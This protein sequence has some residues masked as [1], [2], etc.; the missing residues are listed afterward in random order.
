MSSYSETV[1][2]NRF[3]E[4]TVEKNQADLR[5]LDSFGTESNYKSVETS[6]KMTRFS[7]HTVESFSPL[8]CKYFIMNCSAD[9]R[10]TQAN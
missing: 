7:Q 2:S 4:D 3:L 1:N 5:Y 8:S 9:A 10:N 6:V